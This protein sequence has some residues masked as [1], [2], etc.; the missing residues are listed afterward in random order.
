MENLDTDRPFFKL[1]L[2][3][4][5]LM[6]HNITEEF[7][8]APAAAKSRTFEHAVQVGANC[9]GAWT[10]FLTHQAILPIK[11]LYRLAQSYHAM[12]EKRALVR[13]RRMARLATLNAQWDVN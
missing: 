11:Q 8:R 6:F 5:K 10:L 3:T 7:L 13:V 12:R 1:R 9:R 2:L 4:R